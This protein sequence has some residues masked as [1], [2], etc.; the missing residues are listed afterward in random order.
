MLGEQTFKHTEV[1][2]ERKRRW[3]GEKGEFDRKDIK[4]WAYHMAEREYKSFLK[5]RDKRLNRIKKIDK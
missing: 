1:L 5:T 3:V 4:H 2:A